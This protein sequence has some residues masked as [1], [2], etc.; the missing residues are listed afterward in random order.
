[1]RLRRRLA[2]MLRLSLDC[3]LQL[4]FLDEGR[5]A[6]PKIDQALEDSRELPVRRKNK[7]GISN[8]Y[9][10][11]NSAFFP[12]RSMHLAN[13][14]F[15]PTE[16][17]R[18]GPQIRTQLS[19]RPQSSKGARVAECGSQPGL[20]SAAHSKALPQNRLFKSHHWQRK[21]R[22]R[23]REGPYKDQPSR[24]ESTMRPRELSSTA[25]SADTS[26]QAHK[27]RSTQKDLHLDDRRRWNAHIHPIAI[28]THRQGRSLYHIRLIERIMRMHIARRKNRSRCALD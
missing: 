19:R 2:K 10:S 27:K 9:G 25:S 1:M 16:N 28:H 6:H 23:S 18:D 5:S 8:S 14:C 3:C 26:R 13:Q 17:V 7:A 15:N 22:I 20:F 4:C 12:P 21:D 11:P 24:S